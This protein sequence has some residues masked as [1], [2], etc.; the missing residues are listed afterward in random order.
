MEANFRNI[1]RSYCKP[2]S[3]VVAFQALLLSVGATRS[4]HEGEPNSEAELD[5]LAVV[6]ASRVSVDSGLQNR[7]K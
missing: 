3:K 7:Q 1:A 4:K 2:K 6:L 5:P